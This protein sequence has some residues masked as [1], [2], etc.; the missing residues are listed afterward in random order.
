[1]AYEKL[2]TEADATFSDRLSEQ[3]NENTIERGE[4]RSKQ[5]RLRVWAV[6]NVVTFGFS[7]A[8]F[9]QDILHMILLRSSLQE[10]HPSTV[11]HLREVPKTS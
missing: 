4:L 9:V 10:E 3:S 2:P 5:H 6:M 8:L 11:S 7:V 1:M